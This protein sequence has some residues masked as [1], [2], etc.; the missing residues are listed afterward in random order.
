MF[1]L[2]CLCSAWGCAKSGPLSSLTSGDEN[3]AGARSLASGFVICLETTTVCSCWL[4]CSFGGACDGVVEEPI[5]S[6]VTGLVVVV[7]RTGGGCCG[8]GGGGVGSGGSGGGVGGGGVEAREED[9]CESF[10]ENPDDLWRALLC[11]LRALAC[12]P[13]CGS[14][15]FFS[16]LLFIFN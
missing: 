16:R 8:G 11:F 15:I 5:A 2:G 7:D 14:F 12:V 6:Q 13:R 3:F 4:C 1:C 9:D 10:S